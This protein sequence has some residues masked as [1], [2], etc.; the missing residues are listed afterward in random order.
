MTAKSLGDIVKYVR[1][2][3]EGIETTGVL[4]KQEDYE[5]GAQR[6]G[7]VD[8]A[9]Y[10]EG[11]LMGTGEEVEVYLSIPP[12]RANG[13]RGSEDDLPS[14]GESTRDAPTIALLEQVQ[15]RPKLNAVVAGWRS[16]IETNESH[17]GPGIWG[18]GRVQIKT[19]RNEKMDQLVRQKKLEKRE[20]ELASTAQTALED[21]QKIQTLIDEMIAAQGMK[22]SLVM[23]LSHQTLMGLELD[24]EL[25]KQKAKAIMDAYTG[26]GFVGSVMLRVRRG[27]VV[28]AKGCADLRTPLVPP[29]NPKETRVWELGDPMQSIL[30]FL[31][32]EGGQDL[33]TQK[34]RD[35]GFVMDLIPQV[36]IA[37]GPK[38]PL[39][40]DNP[41]KVEYFK[42][43]KATYFHVDNPFFE[44][45]RVVAARTSHHRKASAKKGREDNVIL[46][47]PHA[48]SKPLGHPLLLD[49]K[50]QST[51]EL[52]VDGFMWDK[53]MPNE[54]GQW[55]SKQNLGLGMEQ[56]YARM[57]AAQNERIEAARAKTA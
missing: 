23:T 51:F 24:I 41:S 7:C 49:T 9:A 15:D 55:A 28:Y 5:P 43:L 31:D 33:F 16:A 54:P 34:A 4:F 3:P 38:G 11:T 22:A 17:C 25:F 45:A 56:G 40:N 6:V 35:A 39:R 42:K 2:M 19:Q 48:I 29:A 8:G 36:V 21:K 47:V 37:N 10:A 57:L 1:H 46:S 20:I 32:Y 14:I 50:Y 13:Y 44:Q 27:D 12:E 52:N 30:K 26:C 53:A 18:V